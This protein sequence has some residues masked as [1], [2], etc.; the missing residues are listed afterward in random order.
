M[1][2]LY[3]KSDWKEV[4]K[5]IKFEKVS[6]REYNDILSALYDSDN[7]YIPHQLQDKEKREERKQRVVDEVLSEIDPSV[8]RTLLVMLENRVNHLLTYKEEGS[9]YNARRV[10]RF[11]VEPFVKYSHRARW[12][13]LNRN[14]RPVAAVLKRWTRRIKQH[15]VNR[16]NVLEDLEKQ[17]QS[18]LVMGL[19]RRA[20]DEA[21]RQRHLLDSM[22]IRAKLINALG[23][24]VTGDANSTNGDF[25]FSLHYCTRYVDEGMGL[26]EYDSDNI[27]EGLK[28]QCKYDTLDDYHKGQADVYIEEIVDY[29][30]AYY[31]AS[32]RWL[33][34]MKPAYDAV[35]NKEMRQ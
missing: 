28:T 25:S 13:E 2:K 10:W 31:A 33:G 18:E 19:R 11:S 14:S 22:T 29:E 17:R 23:K 27:S 8:I 30:Y 15:W 20:N 7:V 9:Y 3:K 32:K 1:A 34:V 6:A 4:D 35:C 21:N 12:T 24:F 5:G 26:K 16:D